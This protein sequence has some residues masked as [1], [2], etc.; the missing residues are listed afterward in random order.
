MKKIVP[1][2]LA[3]GIGER[4]WPMSRSSMPKQ[5][6]KIISDKTMTEET[7]DR[8][9]S[10]CSD[11]V[12]PLIVTG[13]AIADSMKAVLP[14]S[15]KYDLIIE[16]IGK[17]TAPAVALAA[18]WIESAY[19]DSTML[20]LSADHDIRPVEKFIDA[21]KAA[22]ELAESEKCLAV[23]GIKPSRPETG[24]GYIELNQLI[25][26]SGTSQCFAVK[27]FIEKPDTV[28]AQKFLNAGNY[29]WNS[30][31]FVWN[32]SVILEEFAS[33][34]PDLYN[35]VKVAAAAKFSENAI[36]TFYDTCIKESIDFGIM[37]RSKRVNAVVGSFSWDDIGSWE[38]LSRIH[39][40][41]S[42]GTTV[43]G[44]NIYEK[45]C[46]NTIVFNGSKLSVACIGTDD[47]VVVSTN[48]A[49]LVI[50]RK[51]CPDIKKYISEM[52]NGGALPKNLF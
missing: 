32:T 18:Q 17:N 41:N 13:R 16:P 25:K 9:S 26:T 47:L 10:I 19:G 6:L 46:S 4:F 44:E 43:H 1:V 21:V 34:M 28:T 29:M 50:D 35:Q 24:Y 51:K 20:V 52:K 45:D 22:V 11:G 3:G 38:S 39:P 27:Q 14:S 8:I 7:I 49:L 23:F 40:Q 36:K 2:I 5:L 15:L 42:A 48:D 31:M 33:Y 37:E 12:K 30:G